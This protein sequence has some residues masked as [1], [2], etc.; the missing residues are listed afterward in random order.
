MPTK[1]ARKTLSDLA[2]GLNALARDYAGREFRHYSGKVYRVID[3]GLDSE[4]LR[5][6]VFLESIPLVTE[7]GERSPVRFTMTLRR[8]VGEVDDPK[9]GEK[10]RPRHVAIKRR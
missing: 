2:R 7:K 5:P 1:K 10:K 4:T 8:F 3:L 6:T 9:G